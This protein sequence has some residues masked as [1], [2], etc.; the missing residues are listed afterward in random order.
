MR[1]GIVEGKLQSWMKTSYI[2]NANIDRNRWA[3][4][5]KEQI[6]KSAESRKE[7][8]DAKGFSQ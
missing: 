1:V 2:S 4:K 6:D 5:G 7:P 8:L 3:D